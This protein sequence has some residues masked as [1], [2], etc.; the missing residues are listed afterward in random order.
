MKKYWRV[1]VLG[2]QDA[3]VYRLNAVIWVWY[4][5][6][7]AI[8]LMW[9]WQ[10]AYQ[11][12]G[13]HAIGGFD[14]LG[15]MTYYLFVTAFSIVIT[16]HPEYDTAQQIKDGKITQFIV[17]PIGYFGYR[18]AQET[19][20]QTV[21]TTMLL[22]AMGLMICLFRA[23]LRLPTLTGAQWSLF[24]LSSLLAYL[25]LSQ[26]KF[27]L[28]ISAFWIVEPG[29]F[30]EIWNTLVAVMAGRLLPITL[31]P[32]WLQSLGTVLPFASL[33]AFPMRLLLAHA[34][35]EEI[36]LGLTRQLLWLTFLTFVVRWAWR[37]GLR[38][39]EAYG[40]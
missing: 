36:K 13:Q 9:V 11:A 2:W 17:K 37:R 24:L 7:P 38:D 25:I 18:L 8:T 22:P 20:Y 16:P 27:L 10:A 34:T 35:S 28:G 30:L 26:L 15:M 6:L 21:K 31:L 32:G 14:L 29:G 4:S 23:D 12:R 1:A 39:Y 33:Y 40:G 19:A 3:L 5:V